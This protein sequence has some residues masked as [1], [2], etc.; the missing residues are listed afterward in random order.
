MRK[1]WR[2]DPAQRPTFSE[3]ASILDRFLQ[4]V[5]DYTELTMTLPASE[6]DTECEDVE[7]TD[8]EEGKVALTTM[9]T[10]I[11]QW[12]CNMM[13][14]MWNFNRRTS[15]KWNP[16]GKKPCEWWSPASFSL[17]ASSCSHWWRGTTEERRTRL[18]ILY[19]ICCNV[20]CN[21]IWSALYSCVPDVAFIQQP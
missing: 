19:H 7:I 10:T 18:L 1:C 17:P 16:C 12:F 9:H 13:P 3:L 15:F 14:Q 11:L 20:W 5:A 21:A 4:L 2:A 6:A 8:H